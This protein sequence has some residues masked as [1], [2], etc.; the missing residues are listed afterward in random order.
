MFIQVVSAAAYSTGG[1]AAHTHAG[2]EHSVKSL[3][4]GKLRIELK[5]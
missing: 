3:H 5:R 4:F 1:R 2:L